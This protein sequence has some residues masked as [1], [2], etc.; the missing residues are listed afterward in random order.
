M[1]N[2]LTIKPSAA[3]GITSPGE[4]H[5]FI[6]LLAYVTI[7]QG[8]WTW[9]AAS[10]KYL[11]GSL[12]NS[13]GADGDGLT[14]NVFLAANT[15][16]LTLVLRTSSILGIIEILIDGASIATYDAYSSSP[17]DNLI[18]STS[19]ISISSSGL[20]VLTIRING[21]NA[22]STDYKCKISSLTFYRTN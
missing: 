4:G 21:K 7:I 11:G 1:P 12:Y 20:K 16:T 5:I 13:T 19:G 6:N 10:G 8:T 2:Y 18:F 17:A 22:S 3:V 14:Y 9:L 15:Y